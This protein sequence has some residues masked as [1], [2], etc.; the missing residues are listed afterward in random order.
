MLPGMLRFLTTGDYLSFIIIA[1]TLIVAISLH[2][3]GH[4][5][6]AEL[7]GDSTAREAGRLTV[8]PLRHLDPVG[9]LMIVIIGFGWGKPVPISPARMH[10]RRFGSALVGIA[11]PAVNML[12]AIATALVARFLHIPL[13]GDFGG[14][15]GYSFVDR[16]ISGF[17]YINVLL[18][19][20]NL[21]PVPPLDGS[22]VL[23][24]LLPP[25]KQR[26]IF[27]VDQWGFLILLAAALLGLLRAIPPIAGHV[28]GWILTLVGYGNF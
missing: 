22:R 2:E 26:F 28:E 6:A 9:A 19:I 7:Q 5:L 21:I 16:L 11:G 14:I 13:F 3:F 18:A 1:I 4:A 10:N 23:S 20:F 27:F 24:A 12:L 25:S 15:P 17:L 8:N